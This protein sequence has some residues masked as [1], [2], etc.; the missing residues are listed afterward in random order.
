LAYPKKYYHGSNNQKVTGDYLENSATTRESF[1]CRHNRDSAYMQDAWKT[2][3][4]LDI[5][6][7]LGNELSYQIQGCAHIR[8]SIALRSSFHMTDSYY[9]DMC[10]T[11]SNCF[12]CMALRGSEYSILNKKY[13]KEEYLALKAKLIEH[14]KQ[15]GE[16]GNFFDPKSIAPFAYNESV[17][18]DYFPLNKEEAIA[19]GYA[20]YER[21]ARQYP[22]T[23]RS[24][25]IPKTIKY[26]TDAIL[27]ETIE[28]VSQ[29]NGNKDQYPGC[30]TAFRVVQ[31]ELDF[32]RATG[33]PV[34]HKCLPCRRQDRFGLR[35]PRKLWNRTCQCTALLHGHENA[36]TNTFETTYAPDRKEIIYCENCY[37]R[38]VM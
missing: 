6:E 23:M 10:N 11:L 1:N 20:W 19:K 37:Q 26:T 22:V 36:C 8:N 27:Q 34:P 21:P 5:T 2:T 35:N 30:A 32:Y 4:C 17:V 16:W 28:C 15:T 7:V 31:I 13:S 38:E 14:M 24:E 3:D 9:C 18:Y 29:S 25:D 12:G 33:M